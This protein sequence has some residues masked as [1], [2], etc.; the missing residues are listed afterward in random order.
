MDEDQ[1]IHEELRE[2]YSLQER[3]LTIIIAEYEEARS[4]LESNE[5]ARKLH[6]ELCSLAHD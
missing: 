1:R 4:A 6:C 5:R 2:Q 3:K